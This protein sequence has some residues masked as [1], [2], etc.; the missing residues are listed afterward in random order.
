MVKRDSIEP[1][2]GIDLDKI[3]NEICQIKFD[4]L[5][6]L[7]NGVRFA[8]PNIISNEDYNGNIEGEKE[9]VDTIKTGINLPRSINVF[10]CNKIS[11]S[12]SDS[13]TDRAGRYNKKRAPK[14]P[15]TKSE[16]DLNNEGSK[17]NER[18]VKARLVIKT[19][20]V[21][22]VTNI[23]DSKDI[24][25]SNS[26]TKKDKRTGSGCGLRKSARTS[27]E[28]LSKLLTIPRNIFNTA[29]HN[30]DQIYPNDR[31]SRSS[32]RSPSLSSRDENY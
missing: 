3:T 14:A 17:L 23:D 15:E 31:V 4:E 25:V 32:S 18:P 6:E 1:G 2:N 12:N 26:S 5:R 29:F 16:E 24:F 27:K 10:Q 9:N 7:I 20:T 8:V 28:G 30:R 13:C 21:K 22:T 19:G 11:R